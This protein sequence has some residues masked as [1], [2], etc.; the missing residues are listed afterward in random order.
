METKGDELKLELP[1][2][3]NECEDK[4][5]CLVE[6]NATE[7]LEFSRE[8]TEFEESATEE[9]AELVEEKLLEEENEVVEEEMVEEAAGE[10]FEIEEESATDHDES[11]DEVVSE[12]PV[13]VVEE[14]VV[15]DFQKEAEKQP[16]VVQQVPPSQK[17]QR[18]P[19]ISRIFKPVG[20][21]LKRF[22]F[23]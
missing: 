19:Y 1:C 6:A 23:F 22:K 13:L 7:T 12:E 14:Q 11:H 18:Q 15:I 10:D 20:D 4:C 21:Y 8:E 2:K 16:I 3:V 5:E 17:Q 9:K